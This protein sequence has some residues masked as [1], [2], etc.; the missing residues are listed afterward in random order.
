MRRRHV[1]FACALFALSSPACGQ[2]YGYVGLLTSP[3]AGAPHRNL[4]LNIRRRSRRTNIP[5]L[6]WVEDRRT[7]TPPPARGAGP[8]L[9][10]QPFYGTPFEYDVPDP[11]AVGDA[12]KLFEIGGGAAFGAPQLA[13][14]LISPDWAAADDDTFIM[15]ILDAAVVNA[16]PY[17]WVS[18]ALD[19]THLV[20]ARA[21]RCDANVHP[22]RL[23]G[24]APCNGISVRHPIAGAVAPRVWLTT[25]GA[26]LAWHNAGYPGAANPWEVLT[27]TASTDGEND[28]YVNLKNPPARGWV[29]GLELP[30]TICY[31]VVAAAYHLG[32]CF[33]NLQLANAPF[34][35]TYG[36]RFIILARAEIKGQH[37]PGKRL[38]RTTRDR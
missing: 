19:P 16:P 13:A 12:A 2:V 29:R 7:Q 8:A 17:Q 22:P 10:N 14:T 34:E 4:P 9:A 11:A 36:G 26:F 20:P 27:L 38:A 6:Q 5:P 37:A 32:V 21:Q 3:A 18:H 24:A 30:A 15:R 23:N 25:R 1:A 35:I 31:P 33:A 28:W